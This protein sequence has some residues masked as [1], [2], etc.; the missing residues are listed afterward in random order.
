MQAVG[1][2]YVLHGVLWGLNM[3]DVI[4]TVR[5][6]L[7]ATRNQWPLLTSGQFYFPGRYFLHTCPGMSGHSCNAA[8]GQSFLHIKSNRLQ[9]EVS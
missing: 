2:S 1:A 4:Y 8:S 7:A 6:V 3:T 5:T 9:K